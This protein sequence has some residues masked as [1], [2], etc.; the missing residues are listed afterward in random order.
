MTGKSLLTVTLL[1]QLSVSSLAQQPNASPPPKTRPASRTQPAP[2]RQEPD[3]EVVRISTNLVQVDAVVTDRNGKQVTDLTADEIQILEDG[4]P[5]KISNFSFVNSGS[6]TPAT[7]PGKPASADKNAVSLPPTRLR[8]EQVRRTIALVV[9]DL[10]LSFN[11]T[12]YV[13][14]AVKKFIDEQMQEGDLV[15]I[16]RTG[17]GIGALQQFTSDKRM[18]YAAMERIKWNPSGRGGIGAFAPLTGAQTNVTMATEDGE[19]PSDAAAELDR[20]REETFTVGTLGALNYV[21]T[22]LRELPGRK[23]VLLVSD[24]IQMFDSLSRATNFRTQQALTSLIDLANRASVVI[25]TLDA[26]GLQTTGLTA[27]DN[28]TGMS[29]EAMRNASTQRANMIFESQSGLIHMAEQTGGIAFRNSNDLSGGI[30]RVLED[31]T[32][33]YLVGYRPDESTFDQKTGRR[34]F[35]KLELKVTRPGRFLVRMRKGFFGITDDEARPQ[36]AATPQQQI[37]RA[38]T[39]PFGAE[40]VHLRLTSLFGHDAKLGSFMRSL[41]HVDAGDLTFTDQPGGFH[42]AEFDV[43]AITFGDNG[44][45]VNQVGKT[46]SVRLPDKSYQRMLNEG[47]VYFVTVFV[48]KPGAYQLRAALRDHGSERVGSASQFVEVPDLKKNRLTI[49]GIVVTGS[50]PGSENKASG[51]SDAKSLAVQSAAEHQE[52]RANPSNSAAVRRF[53]GG[54]ILEYGFVIY[55]A[56]ADKG[57]PPRLTTQVRIFRDGQPVFSGNENPYAPEGQGDL[58]RLAHGGAIQLGSKMTPGEYVLQVIV[59]DTQAKEKQRTATQW[60]DFEIVK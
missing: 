23:S 46:Y 43:M 39:S 1:V 26:R 29:D 20:L 28:T 31:Q 24:G 15:A 44:S 10:G 9:D 42:Q 56:K 58:K 16:I 7:I 38:L 25:Y 8:P 36:I 12:Y 41:L 22:G 37:L 3:D 45:V 57:L 6:K 19:P 47:F 13:R 14:H 21:V 2:P 48:K 5:Q 30:K 49:S 4:K 11:S 33:Y 53:R 34:T 17:A 40:G 50:E 55:N 35:H 32:S 27:E 59:N 52:D 18:L 51:K 60:I 54:G